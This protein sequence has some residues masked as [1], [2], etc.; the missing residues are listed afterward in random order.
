MVPMYLNF[1]MYIFCIFTGC[2]DSSILCY[3]VTTATFGPPLPA[4]SDAVSCLAWSGGRLASGGWDGRVRVWRCGG[5]GVDGGDALYE[6]SLG[7]SIVYIIK[8]IEYD[9]N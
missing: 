1:S 8:I 5:E 7:K 3:N 2:W 9:F 6:L 4:H